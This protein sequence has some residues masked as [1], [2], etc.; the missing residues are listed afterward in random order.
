MAS[1]SL[2]EQWE[3]EA[4]V[5]SRGRQNNRITIWP[6][7]QATGVA[8][9]KACS[10]NSRLLH[11]TALWW[12]E[13]SDQPA[14]IPINE[15]RY[16]VSRP[17]TK[18]DFLL[19]GVFNEGYFSPLPPRPVS[20]PSLCQVARLR[21]LLVL[22]EDATM[23][24]LDAWGPKRMFTHLLRRW[25]TGASTPRDAWKILETNSCMCSLLNCLEV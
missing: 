23:S 11:L 8:S 2:A 19:E 4:I 14:A 9:M 10:M 22:E 6:S 25:L 3:Q 18:K 21:E 5:R 7:V 13:R 16:Q 20:V 12:V 24:N 1:K 15:L 17:Q